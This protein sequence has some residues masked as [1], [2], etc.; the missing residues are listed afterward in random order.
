MHNNVTFNRIVS[1]TISSVE[2]RVSLQDQCD[3]PCD[4]HDIH[5]HTTHVFI[6]IYLLY[7]NALTRRYF[8]STPRTYLPI[9]QS[10]RRLCIQGIMKSQKTYQTRSCVRYTCS[11]LWYKTADPPPPRRHSLHH[12]FES[13]GAFSLTLAFYPRA[14]ATC[15]FFHTWQM[16]SMI[17]INCYPPCTP[18][19]DPKGWNFF[20]VY[21]T[22]RLKSSQSST[23]STA[24]MPFIVAQ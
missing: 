20:C 24:L 14:F 15:L 3:S 9:Y 22:M 23:A 12:R 1:R 21:A 10:M 17:T 11:I 16:F 7:D 4:S 8:E 6:L 19:E 13:V 5:V 2:N 18:P